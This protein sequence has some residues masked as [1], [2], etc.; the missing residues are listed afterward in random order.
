VRSPG[1]SNPAV[2]IERLSPRRR[3]LLELVS[4][5]LSNDD[6]ARSLAISPATVRTH[7]TTVLA[8]LEVR[9]RTE[10]AG[11]FLAWAAR[12]A[13]V[14][15]MLSRPAIAVL[16]LRPLGANARVGLVAAG[17]T[18][19]LI[20]LFSRWCGFPVIGGI[21]SA[22]GRELGK[23]CGEIGRALGARFIV[24]GAVQLDRAEWRLSIRIDDAR[25]GSCL[26]TDRY[27]FSQT[28]LF[29]VQDEISRAVVAKA[30]PVLVA[31]M[32]VRREGHP[33]ELGAWMLAHDGLILETARDKAANERAHQRFDAA[34][35]LE[36]TLAL[37][38]FGLGLCSY[39]AI[40]NQWAPK[41]E[42]V[43]RLAAATE[44]CLKLAPH[45]AEGH[46]LLG[47]LLQTSA[48][49]ER[50]VRPLEDAVGL[51]PSFARAY[52]LLAQCLIISGRADEGLAR[53]QQAARLSPQAYVSGLGAV[54]FLR[55]EYEQAKIA[56]ERAVLASPQYP[57][58][59]VIAAVTAWSAGD[60]ERAVEH[61]RA[62][63]RANPGFNAR[64]FVA[65]FGAAV[66]GVERIGK[67]LEAI[68]R[69]RP[70]P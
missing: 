59:R 7:L 29:E 69:L 24:D 42:A 50:A 40:L 60:V 14:D 12:P 58:A 57:F 49:H 64:L 67:V 4:R 10:A 43:A 36:P 17:V 27:Q 66:A 65:T 61:R 45:A 19:D 62:L 52:A 54:H 39:G 44:R 33:E 38:H 15:A 32:G 1:S 41:E 53:M 70:R 23:T 5:G 63:L 16:P 51:N 68:D 35:L 34:L 3:E 56:A 13:Q 55:G 20:S 37:A 8:Q 31:R 25:D 11:L 18:E 26:W 28:A 47:R 6:I 2:P 48:D 22:R 30:Y 21:S 46:Y 9:N